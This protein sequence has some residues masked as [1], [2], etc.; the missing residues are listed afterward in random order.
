MV[1]T[2]PDETL[3]EASAKM[4]RHKVGRLPVVD[5]VDPRRVLGYLGRNGIM[6]ARV[7]R[8]DEEH[9]REPGWMGRWKTRADTSVGSADLP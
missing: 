6:E 5:R 9:V 4:L 8:L 7:R 1:V 2:Y 3:H